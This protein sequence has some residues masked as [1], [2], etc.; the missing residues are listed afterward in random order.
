[1]KNW[2]PFTDY[3]FYAYLTSG[4]LSLA[5]WDYCFNDAAWLLRTDWSFMQGVLF[6]AGA[7]VIGHVV[8]S[9]STILLEYGLAR[10]VLTPP[11]EIL[12]GR[13]VPNFMERLV[14]HGVG[15]YYTKSSASDQMLAKASGLL[16]IDQ[17]SLVSESVFLVA[18]S[19]A[20][21]DKDTA[22]R[23][24]EFRNLYGFCRNVAFVGFATSIAAALKPGPAA[25]TLSLGSLV[26]ALAMT[27]RFLKF[28]S[29]FAAEVLRSLLK[30]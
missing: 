7:Y 14:A 28:Y 2:F 12:L 11:V 26:I 29:T 30:N 25:V 1:M 13:K 4:S 19:Q 23:M 17:Q 21:G 18:Y 22:Q 5:A 16:K 10:R 24:D 27:A 6:V 3:D 20:R 9:F 8:A 15:R